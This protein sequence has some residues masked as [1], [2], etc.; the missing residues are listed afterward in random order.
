[1]AF[2][3]SFRVH[4]IDNLG[5]HLLGDAPSELQSRCQLPGLYRKVSRSDGELLDFPRVA[6]ADRRGAVRF[7]DTILD[8]LAPHWVVDRRGNCLDR[9]IHLQSHA[10][11]L[12]APGEFACGTLGLKRHERHVVLPIVPDHHDIR[13]SRACELQAFLDRH[14]RDVFAPGPDDK[15]LVA[16]GD[17]DHAV[18]VDAT[19]VPAVEPAILIDRGRVFVLDFLHVFGAEVCV[20]HIAHHDVATAEANLPL[21]GL[22]HRQ[23]VG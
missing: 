23:R 13:Q 8:V 1:M 5:P 14:R 9:R 16:A 6:L 2:H 20:R 22:R 12:V 19:L 18:G 3:P 7:V 11:E 21:L 15:L 17:A 4:G 10:S